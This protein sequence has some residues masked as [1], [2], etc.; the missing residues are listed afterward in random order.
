MASTVAFLAA[1]SCMSSGFC[2][3]Q[4][5]PTSMPPSRIS[6]TSA[7]VGGRTLN[8][9]SEAAHSAAA[10]GSTSAPASR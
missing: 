5:K 10:V 9:M 1:S 8:T 7:D 3:G 4:T 2:A 6:P